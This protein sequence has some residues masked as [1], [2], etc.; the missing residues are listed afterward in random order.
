MFNM[1][2]LA[3]CVSVQRVQIMVDAK[4]R[5]KTGNAELLRLRADW[6]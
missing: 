6:N 3:A 5:W 4:R 2:R 1:V